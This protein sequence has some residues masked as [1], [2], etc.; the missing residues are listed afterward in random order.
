M[1]KWLL[2]FNFSDLKET[3]FFKGEKKFNQSFKNMESLSKATKMALSSLFKAQQAS[4]YIFYSLVHT[5]KR[6]FNL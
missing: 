1:Q 2:K 4:G 3:Y 6:I 5:T